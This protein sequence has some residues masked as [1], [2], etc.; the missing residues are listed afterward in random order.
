MFGRTQELDLE[1][2]VDESATADLKVLKGSLSEQEKT[3]LRDEL[4]EEYQRLATG[5]ETL[6]RAKTPLRNLPEGTVFRCIPDR[7]G[8]NSRRPLLRL[9]LPLPATT[10]VP[11]A[12]AQAADKHGSPPSD[13][14]DGFLRSLDRIVE[15]LAAQVSDQAEELALQYTLSRLKAQV[16][17]GEAEAALQ[18]YLSYLNLMASNTDQDRAAFF[19]LAA[20]V[21]DRC[22]S[23]KMPITTLKSETASLTRDHAE[24]KAER[25][26]NVFQRLYRRLFS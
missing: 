17:G 18:I 7:Q 3:R 1:F 13:W 11:P 21:I 10:A 4:S 15:R 14:F 5:S 8:V 26:S 19:T 25:S 6:F 22:L 9:S 23:D 12:P 2:S 16:Q 20:R 24:D